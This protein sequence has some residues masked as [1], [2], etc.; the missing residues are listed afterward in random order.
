MDVAGY[1]RL[2]GEDEQGTL[3]R[4]TEHRTF[5]DPIGQKHGGRIVKTMGDGVLVEFPSVIEAV[6]FALRC[7]AVMAER[8][9]DVPDDQRMLFRIGIN[10]GD[11]LVQDDDIFGDGVNVAARIEALAEPGGICI[12]RTVRDN[13]RDRM[14]LDF[15]DMGEVEVKNIA[16]PVRVFRV[17]AVPEVI[18]A[19]RPTAAPASSPTQPT[20]RRQPW[21]IIAA[22]AA[23]LVIVIV[24]GGYWWWLQP[25]F[26]PADPT[27]FAYA[28]PDKPSIAVLPFDN[29][30][31][32][33]SHDY[34]GYGMTESIIAMLSMSPEL[35]VISRKSSATFKGNVVKVQ[36]VAERLGVQY[37]LEGSVQTADNRIRVSAQLVDALS[38]R[39][40][41]SERYDRTA[42]DIFDVQDD[43]AKSVLLAVNIRVA[44]GDSARQTWNKFETFEAWRLHA[45]AEADFQRWSAEGNIEAE[46]LIEQALAI[47]PDNMMLYLFLGYVHWQKVVVGISKDPKGDLAEMRR[48]AN[49]AVKKEPKSPNAVITLANYFLIV[50]QHD[51]AVELA[52]KAYELSPTYGEIAALAGWTLSWSGEYSEGLKLLELGARLEAYHWSWIP[53][54]MAFSHYALGRFDKAK[55]LS[56]SILDSERHE[57]AA[58]DRALMWLGVIAV[59]QNRIEDAERHVAEWQ[60]TG[61][62]ASVSDQRRAYG[63]VKDKALLAR[64]LDSLRKAGL[65]EYRPGKEPKTE[66][67]SIAV[68]PFANLSDDREQEYFADGMTDDLITDLSKVSGLIVIAR[69]SVFTYKGKNV[70]V[71]E[72]ARDLNVTHVLEGSVRRDK[73]QVRINAQLI[74]AKTGVHLWG[75]TFDRL[76]KDVFALQDEITAK[77]VAAMQ[78]SLTPVEKKV[79]AKLPTKDV[80]AYDHF[81]KAE[82]LRLTFDWRNYDQ[83]LAEYRAA[84]SRDPRFVAAHLGLAR[85]LVR[86]WRSGWSTVMPVPSQ[87]LSQAN[88]TLQ[89]VDRLDPANPHK[90]VIEIRIAY[91]QG[92]IDNGLEMAKTAVGKYPSDVELQ[93]RLA[94]LLVVTGALSEA[95]VVAKQ[96][97]LLSVRPDRELWPRLAWIFAYVGDYDRAK[98]MIE[99]ARTAGADR[100]ETAYT[101]ARVLVGLGD[102]EAAKNEV[103]TIK[104]RWG[105]ANLQLLRILYQHH[106]DPSLEQRLFEPLAAAG[107]PEWPQGIQFDESKRLDNRGLETLFTRPFSIE[108]AF[109]D[110]IGIKEN[111]LCSKRGWRLMGRSVCRPVYHDPQFVKELTFSDHQYIAPS[112]HDE[113]YDVFSVRRGNQ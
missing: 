91:L 88:D 110:V 55:E 101:M 84:L 99:R 86:I 11:V 79:V 18:A 26:E 33:K 64:I 73:S 45:K 40:L 80:V 72:I 98:D 6:G 48:Y 31:G 39:Y 34:L 67:P 2:M 103:R 106:K 46:N 43:I 25:D 42:D 69:N 94:H 87:A 22:A 9:I 107:I 32:N 57:P 20:S 75:E 14:D 62:R 54:Q 56:L 47:E 65:A 44:G 78:V 105:G 19:I 30:S 61:S 28:L 29:L 7:Q 8:N 93:Y 10:L 49:L 35:Y 97:L 4:L 15:D 24:G 58:R 100:F 104:A 13:V 38:G 16:R 12:S 111:L 50:G 83:A 68:L 23:I 95:Q 74:D 41:W 82:N 51:K 102:L 53:I 89:T 70:K 17:S 113:G 96:A 36:Q 52:R 109:F 81:L 77:I 90:S 1:S 112:V 76:F 60:N 3:A 66:K 59:A 37:V 71:Q 21:R 27:K 92:D 63:A 108:G 85:A 5:I